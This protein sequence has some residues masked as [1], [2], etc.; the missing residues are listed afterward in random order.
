[1]A[2]VEIIEKQ[3][4]TLDGVSTVEYNV[5]VSGSGRYRSA[6]RDISTEHLSHR[7]GDII[8]DS[9][10]FLNST[11]SYPCWIAHTFASDFA[12]FRNFLMNHSDKYYKL[13]DTYDG[14]HFRMAR[15]VGPIEPSTKVMLRVGTFD[16]QFDC[17][18]QIF[19]NDGDTFRTVSSQI[20]N[21]TDF[22]C[23]PILSV[24][25][26]GSY[27]VNGSAF[28]VSGAT[29]FPVFIDCET[30]DAYNSNGD[31]MNKYVSLPVR[32]IR[33]NPG[34]NSVSGTVSI[35]PRWFDM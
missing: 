18:P 35:K 13:T 16:V 27:K 11:I 33:L 31:N 10:C 30:M 15:V 20:T 17:K 2:D 24:S 14:N 26:N 1:M 5:G 25:S 28:T 8:T 4:F 6:Q 19:R 21:P 23:F 9:G 12:S 3:S 32:N 7:N 34:S 29:G 22:E